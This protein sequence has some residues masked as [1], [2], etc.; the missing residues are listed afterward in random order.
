MA[1][2]AGSHLTERIGLAFHI[3]CERGKCI[4]CTR[5]TAVFMAASH[6]AYLA[7]MSRRVWAQ[8]PGRYA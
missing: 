3:A 4:A 1:D 6:A 7:G 5:N 8:D 2:E